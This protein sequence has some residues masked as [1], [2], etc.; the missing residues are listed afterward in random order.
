MSQPLNLLIV[1]DSQDDADLLVRELRRAGFSPVWKR[2]ETEPDFLTGLG[3]KPDLI[4]SDYSMPQF[5][6]L[7]AAELAR[8]SG[9]HVP[10]ILISGTVGEDIAVEAMRYGA[11]DYLL[12]DRLGRLGQA[13]EHAL[14]QAREQ[15]ER[16]R[17]QGEV[18]I[19]EQRLNA[20]FSAATAGLVLL[21]RDLRYVRINETLAQI[22]GVPAREH[23]GRTVREVLPRFAPQVE[24]LLRR[25]LDS[26]QAVLNV[27]TAGETPLQPGV[28]RH[29]MESFF[30][31][32][33]KDGK[34]V[35]VG[36]VVVETTER[37]RAESALRESEEKFRQ[38]AES[39]REVFWILEPGRNQMIYVSPAYETIWG[40]SCE[41]LYQSP[42]SWLEA[43]HA[44]DRGRIEEAFSNHLAGGRF[45]VTY[46]I[47]RPDRAVRWI[48]DR[49]FPV[50]N[51]AGE[52]YRTVGVAEDITEQRNLEEQFRQAQKMEAIGQLAGGVA[53]DF[54]NVLAVIGM[55]CALIKSEGE[56]SP[57]Q[58]E[59]VEG[60]GEAAR[61]ADALV[62]QLLLF[63]RRQ[64]MQ[65]RQLELNEIVS[66]LGRMLRRIIGEDVSLELR[67]HA[68]R[69]GLRADAGMVEQVLMN[70][71]VNA[72]DA[73]PGGGR[74]GI[75]TGDLVV[76]ASG[77]AGHPEA[78]PGRYVWFAVSDTGQGIAPE[79]L[80]RIF[81]P[82]FTTKEPGKGTGLGLA[83]VFGIVNQHRGWINVKSEP[84]KGT[85]FEVFLPSSAAASAEVPRAAGKFPPRGGTETI[86]LAEDDAALRALTRITLE[87]Q[88]Y[89]VLEFASGAE[90]ATLGSERCREA[91][92]LL[93]DLVMPGGV[94]G[95]QLA[96]QL[97]RDNPKLKVIYTSGF[98]AETAGRELELRIGDNY[99]QKPCPPEV[100][101]AT[102]RRCLD[103]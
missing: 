98:S 40:R 70:L 26:G 22:N 66:G 6:G 47:L 45:D 16:M 21:D 36:A 71:V 10:F 2:V 65:P 54:N 8:N 67:P 29:W 87:R 88:G 58:K 60:V 55:S 82:F 42:Q 28:Q 33:G 57:E 48:H 1:E 69:L 95:H 5:S 39:I 53:H 76:E 27:E 30:P 12:K 35:A 86:V 90:A 46:R 103:S 14:R 64:I 3:N 89:R 32:P 49:A 93:T 38:I 44:E 81:E 100:L 75:E 68:G 83:T 74:M 79:V 77:V 97:L 37:W 59:H 61:R 15:E 92:L 41:S 73:M 101:L 9:L 34:P 80:P 17:L 62:R 7:R 19:R 24:P 25:V 94:S 31:I 13:V 56:L 78:A 63:S 85:R 91:A 84:G 51:A 18:E 23:L 99:M 50:R 43:I 102:V 52:V 72:R 4:L 96:Q 11:T 20:F